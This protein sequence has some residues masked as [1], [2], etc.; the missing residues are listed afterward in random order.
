MIMA[1]EGLDGLKIGMTF[2]ERYIEQ[3]GLLEADS[4]NKIYGFAEKPDIVAIDADKNLGVED[5]SIVFK[6]V[7]LNGSFGGNAP[8]NLEGQAL[9]S[10][11]N[12]SMV[13]T[14]VDQISSQFFEGILPGETR[15]EINQGD[16]TIDIVRDSLL[17]TTANQGTASRVYLESFKRIRYYPGHE[18]GILFTLGS[19][20]IPSAGGSYVNGGL[21]DLSDGMFITYREDIEDNQYKIGMLIRRKGADTVVFQNEFSYD[22]LDGTGKSKINI[23][24]SNGNIFWLRGGYLGFAPLKLYVYGSNGLLYLVHIYEYPNKNNETNIANVRLPASIEVSNGDGTEDVNAYIGSFSA[25]TASQPTTLNDRPY[26]RTRSGSLSQNGTGGAL[27]PYHNYNP[28]I[29]FRATEFF[30]GQYQSVP[31]KNYIPAIL[32]RLESITAAHSKIG[33]LTLH[34]V[35]DANLTVNN[36]ADVEVNGSALQIADNIQTGNSIVINWTGIDDEKENPIL[37]RLIRPTTLNDI[38]IDVLDYGRFDLQYPNA[39][40]LCLTTD[41]NTVID[42]IAATFIWFEEH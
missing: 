20:N 26:V 28:I 25:Y 39:A 37:S 33:N 4:I 35:P 2:S 3:N 42:P 30:Q 18:F 31:V 24:F 21:G 7:S 12:K 11:F 23:N 8:S 17:H 13:E 27:D 34:V 6:L 15:N 41:S 19:D 40:V 16:T 29:A 38:A 10:I 5:N 14:I 36:W 22:K 1:N 32:R 9:T